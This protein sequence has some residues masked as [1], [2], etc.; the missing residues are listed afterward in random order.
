LIIANGYSVITGS[1]DWNEVIAS[2]PS[3]LGATTI[4]F[5]KEIDKLHQDKS[6]GIHTLPLMLG[7]KKVRIM[8]LVMVELLYLLVYYLVGT[9]YFTPFILVVLLA[10]ITIRLVLP[11]FLKPKPENRPDDCPTN[12]WSFWFVAAAFLHNRRY[13][14]LFLLGL[15][16]ELLIKVF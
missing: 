5:G 3:G 13:V 7:E 4:I 15:I 6:R 1:W 11:V 16:L 10:L 9:V 8:A 2:L 14:L 12:V